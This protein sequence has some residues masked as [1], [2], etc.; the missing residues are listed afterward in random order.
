[1]PC[2]LARFQPDGADD[3][4]ALQRPGTRALL[5]SIRAS[6]RSHNRALCARLT[7]GCILPSSRRSAV[8]G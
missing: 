8:N 3:D 5:V 1:V 4:G 2:E 6:H 7:G